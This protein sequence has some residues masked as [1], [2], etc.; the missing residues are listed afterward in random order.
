M[1]Q[2]GGASRLGKSISQL[3]AQTAVE[4]SKQVEQLGAL[5]APWETRLFPS[6]GEQHA[7]MGAGPP[8]PAGGTEPSPEPGSFN[9]SLPRLYSRPR[10][11]VTRLAANGNV[12]YWQAVRAADVKE[13][14]SWGCS[15]GPELEPAAASA[16]TR[17]S[18]AATAAAGA[19]ARVAAGVEAARVS[20]RESPVPEHLKLCA[21]ALQGG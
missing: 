9:A 5:H 11:E 19:G 4:L 17:A 7:P 3:G 18:G 1:S 14:V 21:G 6:S 13:E 20:C 12:A 15:D 8:L 2:R 16:A 10:C